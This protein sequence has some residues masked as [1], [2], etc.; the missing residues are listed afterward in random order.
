VVRWTN[1]SNSGSRDSKW[2]AAPTTSNSGIGSRG[3]C[4]HKT[5]E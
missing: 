5:N 4:D 3:V 2:N 1:T